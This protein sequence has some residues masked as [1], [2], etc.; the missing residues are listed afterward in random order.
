MVKQESAKTTKERRVLGK[1]GRLV[2]PASYRKVLALREGDE[3]EVALD[4]DAI[5]VE[6]AAADT[7]RKARAE[8]LKVSASRAAYLA[9]VRRIQKEVRRYVPRGVSLVD[10]LLKERREEALRE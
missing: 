7:P 4:Q 6:K 9:K 3:L 2:L 10:E 1:G 5:R 8:R